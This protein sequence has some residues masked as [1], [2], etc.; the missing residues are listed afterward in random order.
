MRLN[1][2][3]YVM[4]GSGFIYNTGKRQQVLCRVCRRA[5][6]TGGGVLILMDA[7]VSCCKKRLQCNEVKAACADAAKILKKI[8]Y[9]FTLAERGYE[10][11]L[12]AGLG[13]NGRS[14]DP[15]IWL[16]DFAG[17]YQK[18]PDQAKLTSH[19][20]FDITRACEVNASFRRFRDKVLELAKM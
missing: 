8:P 7:D 17:K 10:S 1:V 13:G 6:A 11:W 16:K 5:H 19:P 3:P 4:K 9:C 2:E 12:V 20:E 15:R 14:G 18:V